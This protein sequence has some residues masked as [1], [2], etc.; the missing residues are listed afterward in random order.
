MYSV[1]LPEPLIATPP[2]GFIAA[3][4]WR[5]AGGWPIGHNQPTRLHPNLY[6]TTGTTASLI[7]AAAHFLRC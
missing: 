5:Q 4:C 3:A 7:I 2:Y 6:T 1:F